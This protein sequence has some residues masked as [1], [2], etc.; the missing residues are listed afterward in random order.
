M[1][2][3]GV[4]RIKYVIELNVELETAII[5]MVKMDNIAQWLAGDRLKVD[6]LC[7]IYKIQKIIGRSALKDFFLGKNN[8]RIME[9][10]IP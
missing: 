1:H 8:K 6:Q 4:L 5:H 2:K 7:F 3:K 10:V 9:S